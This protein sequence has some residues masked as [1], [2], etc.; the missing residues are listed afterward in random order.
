MG[1]YSHEGYT[2]KTGPGAGMREGP[3][4]TCRLKGESQDYPDEENLPSTMETYAHP[5]MKKKNK[6]I[7]DTQTPVSGREQ[8]TTETSCEESIEDNSLYYPLDSDE[9]PPPLFFLTIDLTKK[10]TPPNS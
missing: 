9:A 8:K 4:I 2:P 3:V 1:T 7:D 5:P 6:E 10:N